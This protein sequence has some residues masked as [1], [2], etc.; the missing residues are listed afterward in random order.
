M[1]H[2][3]VNANKRS[4]PVRASSTLTKEG[5]SVI[6]WS[7]NQSQSKIMSVR[8]S[9]CLAHWGF[10]CWFVC[11]IFVFLVHHVSQTALSTQFQTCFFPPRQFD[12]L[13]GEKVCWNSNQV[14]YQVIP[15]HLINKQQ[16]TRLTWIVWPSA[17]LKHRLWARF[18]A[19]RSKLKTANFREA[20]T[21]AS[22]CLSKPN[23]WEPGVTFVCES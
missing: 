8:L 4:F 13:S 15:K 23:Q 3:E 21:G 18:P 11:L 19:G 6:L 16:E 9:A 12:F 14:L 1:H 17:F 5:I 20:V 2:A 7:W 10:I 22:Q